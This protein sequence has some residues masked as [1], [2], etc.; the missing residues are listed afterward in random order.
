LLGGTD[1]KWFDWAGNDLAT[2][3]A[4]A[5]LVVGVAVTAGLVRWASRHY[6]RSAATSWRRTTWEK[7]MEAD[8]AGR[9]EQEAA[10]E[11]EPASNARLSGIPRVGSE[12]RSDGWYTGQG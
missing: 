6:V 2:R 8:C 12:D 10:Y 5:G 4:I 11:G 9:R 1:V 7:A 3:V